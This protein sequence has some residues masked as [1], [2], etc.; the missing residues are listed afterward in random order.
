M[1]PLIYDSNFKLGEEKTQVIAQISFPDL[2]PTFFVK[3]SLFSLVFVIGKP[4]HWDITTINKTRSS[5]AKLKV[6]LDLLAERHQYMMIDIENEATKEVRSIKVKIKYDMTP[7]YSKKCKLQGNE[8]VECRV[9]HIELR[10]EISIEE[11]KEFQEQGTHQGIQQ[12]HQKANGQSGWRFGRGNRKWHSTN[13]RFVKNKDV[14]YV[15]NDD[16]EKKEDPKK[17]IMK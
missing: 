11:R 9:L 17:E 2:L 13:R 14:E 8:E 10:K 5:C 15:P 3:E 12:E 1:R 6:Q 4:L 7:S 16:L